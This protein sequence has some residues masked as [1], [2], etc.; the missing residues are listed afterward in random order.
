[1][2]RLHSWKYHF[3]KPPKTIFHP[4]GHLCQSVSQPTHK[5]EKTLHARGDGGASLTDLEIS[6]LDDDA[7]AKLQNGKFC[8]VTVALRGLAATGRHRPPPTRDRIARPGVGSRC[9]FFQLQPAEQPSKLMLVRSEGHSSDS[10]QSQR[11][12]REPRCP[13]LLLL[14]LS[15]QTTIC[16]FK[17]KTYL[18][19]SFLSEATKPGRPCGEE[20]RGLV[21][22]AMSQSHSGGLTRQD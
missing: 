14:L 16:I 19:P 15:G 9:P 10:T 13:F 8:R 21:T 11:E 17:H 7:P 3:P 18:R 12:K 6:P 22:M 4:W 20:L 1:M 2:S 5:L